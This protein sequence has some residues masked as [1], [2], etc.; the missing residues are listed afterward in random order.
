[1]SNVFC[2]FY[3]KMSPKLGCPQAN[4]NR[5]IVSPYPKQVR[6]HIEFYD[7]LFLASYLY[8]FNMF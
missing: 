6:K 1:M 5:K 8:I 7:K 3:E 4:G 2:Y